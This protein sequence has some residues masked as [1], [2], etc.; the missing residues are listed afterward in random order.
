MTI[1]ANVPPA[2]APAELHEADFLPFAE[3]SR[4]LTAAQRKAIRNMAYFRALEMRKQ[5][6][7]SKEEQSAYWNGVAT[8]FFAC[9]SQMKIPAV[10][11]LGAGDILDRVARWKANGQ[12]DDGA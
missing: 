1:A 9:Q 4:K 6:M 5:G 12:I 11:L 7:W 10:W 3:C 8:A 2:E